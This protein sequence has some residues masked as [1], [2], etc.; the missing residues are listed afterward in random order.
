MSRLAPFVDAATS[1]DQTNFANTYISYY[2]WGTA[3]GLGLDLSLRDRTDGKVTLDDFMRA[4]W[5]A[6]A[7]RHRRARVRRDAVHD[8]RSEGPCSGPSPAMRRLRQTSSLAI[9]R[10]TRFPTTRGSS[11]EQAFG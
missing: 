2:T 1:I 5:I 8:R 4:L 6:S 11:G 7:V 9:S 3:L 10:V